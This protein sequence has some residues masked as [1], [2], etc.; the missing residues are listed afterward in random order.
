MRQNFHRRCRLLIWRHFPRPRLRS[1]PMPSLQFHLPVPSFRSFPS[2]VEVAVY[3]PF[4]QLVVEAAVVEEEEE[5][6]V[7]VAA[8]AAE[9]EAVVEEAAARPHPQAFPSQEPLACYCS[10]SRPCFG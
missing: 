8:V 1:L 10:A 9:E 7:V 5:E 4:P 3:H 2:P 6:V